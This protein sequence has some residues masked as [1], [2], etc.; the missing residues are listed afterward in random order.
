M[1]PLVPIGY[2]E[3]LDHA[4]HSDTMKSSQH[5]AARAANQRPAIPAVT[6]VDQTNRAVFATSSEGSPAKKR[7]SITKPASGV[8]CG[9]MCPDMRTV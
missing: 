2:N 1:G 8:N 3:K 7:D 4:C 5:F 9:T 6:A